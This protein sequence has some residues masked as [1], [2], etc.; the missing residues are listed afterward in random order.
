MLCDRIS[1]PVD[2]NMPQP[3]DERH[4]QERTKDSKLNTVFGKMEITKS[5]RRTLRHASAREGFASARLNF[6]V[7]SP[8]PFRN[9]CFAEFARLASASA[10]WSL[11]EA[12]CLGKPIV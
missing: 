10:G 11:E 2:L 6:H 5:F 7:A 12:A 1:T 4:S 8:D 9:G 3:V